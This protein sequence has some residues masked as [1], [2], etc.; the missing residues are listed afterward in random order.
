MC[1]LIHFQFLKIAMYTDSWNIYQTSS[2]KWW[3]MIS[4]SISTTGNCYFNSVKMVPF[5]HWKMFG[6]LFCLNYLNFPQPITPL[7]S[8]DSFLC[9]SY[10]VS[11]TVAKT[12]SLQELKGV[13][14]GDDILKILFS[15]QWVTAMRYGRLHSFYQLR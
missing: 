7:I 3:V 12:V 14:S 9:F 13:F 1:I 8:L 5:E 2:S 10:L 4:C 6:Y 15:M 11:F